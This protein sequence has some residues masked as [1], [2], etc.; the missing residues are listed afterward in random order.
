MTSAKRAPRVYHRN[1]ARRYSRQCRSASHEQRRRNDQRVACHVR[2]PGGAEG[3]ANEAVKY[4]HKRVHSHEPERPLSP[5]P[6]WCILR[7]PIV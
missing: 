4:H 1:Q 5:L 6:G 2:K 7:Q 3:A